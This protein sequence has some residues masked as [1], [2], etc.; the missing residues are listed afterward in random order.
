M[1]KIKDF[2]ENTRKPTGLLGKLMIKRMNIR[3]TKVSA[4]G[5]AHL[6]LFA[7]VDILEIGCGGGKMPLNYVG[8]F[9]RPR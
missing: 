7:P 5:L 3:H 2:Y 9:Q 6:K 8:C 1:E 4:W